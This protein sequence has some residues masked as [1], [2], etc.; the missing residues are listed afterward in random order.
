MVSSMRMQRASQSV[1]GA[2]LGESAEPR[3]GKSLNHGG[4]GA[5]VAVILR[6]R[7]DRRIGSAYG[8]P[9]PRSG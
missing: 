6:E 4:R 1:Q 3:L 8:D 9:S 7:S 5:L 2:E